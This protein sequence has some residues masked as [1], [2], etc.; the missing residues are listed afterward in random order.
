M[1][2]GATCAVSARGRD[3]VIPCNEPRTH[4][5]G[6]S[7][8]P[9]SLRP[10]RAVSTDCRVDSIFRHMAAGTRS[11]ISSSCLGL[12]PYALD[13][14]TLGPPAPPA[15][16]FVVRNRTLRSRVHQAT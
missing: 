7:G 1:K 6:G 12:S 16:F 5:L 10:A 2:L 15:G 8:R 11:N 14:E 9:F 13:T 4:R 3:G